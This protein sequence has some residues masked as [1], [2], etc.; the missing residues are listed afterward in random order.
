MTLVYRQEYLKLAQ[1][2][3][4]PP[5]LLPQ[6]WL[7]QALPQREGSAGTRYRL[8]AHCTEKTNVPASVGQWEQVF[9]RLGLQLA[10]MTSGCC[11]MSGTYGHE[12]RNV[13]TSKVI[14]EQ[15]WGRLLAT[16]GPVSDGEILATGYSC[17][18]Q[19]ERLYHRRLRHPVEVLLEKLGDRL[20]TRTAGA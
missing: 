10:P 9:A 3:E 11:G 6:E 4:C 1:A 12:S 16:P 2:Q 5:V 17:R 13:A 14:F 7:L 8:L 18:S 15:S 19:T 20:P